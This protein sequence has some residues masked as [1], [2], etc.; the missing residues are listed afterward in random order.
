MDRRLRAIP[1]ALLLLGTAHA[2]SPD[3]RPLNDAFAG[4][5]T[6]KMDKQARLVLDHYDQGNRFRQD[7]L[8]LED[9]APDAI[10]FS[11]EEDGIV[12]KCLPDKAQCI[13]KEIFKLDVVRLTSRVT[14]PRPPQDVEGSTSIQLLRDLVLSVQAVGEKSRDETPAKPTRRSAR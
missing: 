1:I 7:V 2:Q 8:R 14:I 6:F 5:V 11:A 13:S 3:L 12:L 9:L 4:M 10:L